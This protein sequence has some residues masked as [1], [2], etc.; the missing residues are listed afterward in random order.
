M[1][2]LRFLQKT[3]K[4]PR[5]CTTWLR[6]S[7]PARLIPGTLG[8]WA[9]VVNA[10]PCDVRAMSEGLL[11]AM[12]QEDDTELEGAAAPYDED[13]LL[14]KA[15]MTGWKYSEEGE[16]DVDVLVVAAV[17][18]IEGDVTDNDMLM[19]LIQMIQEVFDQVGFPCPP[20]L[21]SEAW[22]NRSTEHCQGKVYW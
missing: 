3:L 20:P 6:P 16:R 1:S 5:G 11:A 15:I 9:L 10:H 7:V 17:E 21:S 12:I 22:E 19:D 2:H 8:L 18:A 14:E 4:L 13:F